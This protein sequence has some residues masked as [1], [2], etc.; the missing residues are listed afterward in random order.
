MVYVTWQCFQSIAGTGDTQMY[1]DSVESSNPA[2]GKLGRHVSEF[3][4]YIAN[5][6]AF[7]PNYGDVIG[8][9]R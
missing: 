9:V 6:K 2:L 5:N 1:L 3:N 4:T 8:M 7:V